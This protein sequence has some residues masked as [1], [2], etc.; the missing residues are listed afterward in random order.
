VSLRVRLLAAV[1]AITI[2]AL[3]AGGFATYSILSSNLFDRLDGMLS[4]SRGGFESA[5]S[6]GVT[7]DCA[8]GP[9]I[10]RPGRLHLPPTPRFGHPGTLLATQYVEILSSSGHVVRSQNCPAYIGSKPYRPV[11]P[12]APALISSLDGSPGPSY[13]TAQSLTQGGPL[14]YVAVSRLSNG[15]LLVQGIVIT[16]T[17]NTLHELLVAELIVGVVALTVAILV[18]WVLVRVGLRPLREVSETATSITSGSL[19]ERVRTANPKTEIGHV[20]SAFNAMLDQIQGAFTERD[21]SERQLRQFVADASHELRTP[22]AAISAYAELFGRGA[23]KDAE[24]LERVLGGIKRE[25]KRMEALVEDLLI[26][27]RLDEGVRGQ[28]TPVELVR[29]C[30]FIVEDATEIAP[31]WATK[32][33]ASNP[34]EVEGDDGQLRCAV[35]NL[36]ANV[37]E[38]TEHGTAATLAVRAEGDQAIIEVRDDGA[39]MSEVAVQHAFDRFYRG[40]PSRSRGRGGSGLGLAI[41]RAIAIAHGGT[42]TL[43]SSPGAGTVVRIQLPL[44]VHVA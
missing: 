30:S 43:T 8:R 25:A 2:L 1:A 15:N 13:L 18:G 3:S 9:G 40:D 6:Q 27:A 12:S 42:T 19:N 4:A 37:R 26:L 24:D 39:G 29:L 22:L 20:G 5:A 44:A 28:R 16:D 21:A 38:H 36:L 32:L 7:I 33:V 31:E 14:F 23:D 17:V 34:L 41:V 35:A 10:L 11:V